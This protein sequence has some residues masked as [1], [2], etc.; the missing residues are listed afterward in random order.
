MPTKT[1]IGTTKYVVVAT[2]WKSGAG[3][4]DLV[5]VGLRPQGARRGTLWVGQ[6]WANAGWRTHEGAGGRRVARLCD[7]ARERAAAMGWTLV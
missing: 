4:S 7:Y 2:A 1:A 5:R 6:T 3:R